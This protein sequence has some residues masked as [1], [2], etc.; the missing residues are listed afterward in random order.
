MI[1]GSTSVMLADS[2]DSAGK[3]KGKISRTFG[4]APEEFHLLF[5]MQAIPDNARSLESIG[6]GDGAALTLVRLRPPSALDDVIDDGEL[7]NAMGLD[8]G[9]QR[10]TYVLRADTW[11]QT[12]STL[13]A[14]FQA[15]LESIRRREAARGWLAVNAT[16]A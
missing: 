6:V 9:C 5:A 7:I 10:R 15:S 13:K 2:A 1:D 4:I 14:E 12:A 8:L 11:R 3:L 16:A